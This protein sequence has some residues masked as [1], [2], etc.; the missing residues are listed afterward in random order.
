MAMEL[1]N[2]VANTV[3]IKAREGDRGRTKKWKEVL[4]LPLVSECMHFKDEIEHTFEY[5]VEGQPIGE[6]LFKQ[7]CSKDPQLTRCIEYLSA[8]KKFNMATDE[9]CVAD[10]RSVFDEY[11]SIRSPTRVQTFSEELAAEIESRLQPPVARSLF[12]H[13]KDVLR[14]FLSGQPFISYTESPYYLRYLQWILLERMPVTKNSFRQYRVLGKGGFGLVYACQAKVSGKMYALKKL[15]K[16][17][18]KKRKGEKMALNEK[19]I[20]EQVHSR[21]VVNLAYAYQSKDSLCMVLTLMD[22]GDLRFHI[23]NIG[24]PGLGEER[25]VFH[26]AELACGLHHLH[27]SRIAYRDM[28]P[29]NILLDEKGHIRISDLG[30]AIQIPPDQSVRGRVGTIGYMA[31]EVIDHHRYTFAPDWWGLGCVVFEM[32]EGECP[33]RKKDRASREEVE[34]RVKEDPVTF[35]DQFSEPSK[36]FCTQLLDKSPTTRLGANFDEVR[37]HMFFRGVNWTQLESGQ[38]VPPF[39]LNPKAVYA[40]DVLDIDQFSSVKGVEMEGEDEE[41]AGKFATGAVSKPWQ[42]EMIDSSV[43]EDIN[44]LTPI[45]SMSAADPSTQ[46]PVTEQHTKWYHRLFRR[47]TVASTT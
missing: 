47:R 29:E 22:G 17:R 42:E 5:L 44:K 20:L 8:V 33:F 4:K 13:S 26:A 46:T 3:Y 38:A 37:G 1:E 35:S 14:E 43:F 45:E 30:L 21:F 7:F 16:K 15:D 32:I 12:Q 25:A 18:V 39:K 6:Q 9:E 34:R 36:L 24:R 28:K 10:A 19:Q 11:I 23:H 40:K 41:F 2:I 27:S 31:P